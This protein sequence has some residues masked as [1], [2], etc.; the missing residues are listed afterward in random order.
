MNSIDGTM[1][2]YVNDKP[3]T[4]AKAGDKVHVIVTTNDGKAVKKL[5]VKHADGKADLLLTGDTFIMPE[6]DIRVVADIE[7]GYAITLETNYTGKAVATVGGLGVTA[8]SRDSKVMIV[9][10]DPTY[11][12]ESVSA[13]YRT[14]L[15]A[16]KDLAITNNGFAMPEAAVTVKVTLKPVSTFDF[17]VYSVSDISDLTTVGMGSFFLSVNNGQVNKAA[18][19]TE[20]KIVAQPL[21]GYAITGI[22]VTKHDDPSKMVSVFNNTFTMPAFDVDVIVEFG[23]KGNNIVIMPAKGGTAYA[24]TTAD[25]PATE[26]NTGVEVTLVAKPL[27]GYEIEHW[28]VVRNKDGYKVTVSSDKFMMPAGGVTVTPVFIGKENVAVTVDLYL[29]DTKVTSKDLLLSADV[30]VSGPSAATTYKVTADVSGTDVKGAA[31]PYVGDYISVGYSCP[32]NIAFEK[33]KINAGTQSAEYMNQLKTHD[34]FELADDTAV[35]IEVYFSKGKIAL[36]KAAVKGV[37]SVSYVSGVDLQSIGSAKANDK[38]IV[39]LN[40]GDHYMFDYSSDAFDGTFSKYLHVTRKDNGA[41]IPLTEWDKNSDGEIDGYIFTMPDCGI[42]V[43]AE[44]LSETYTIVMICKDV[45]DPNNPIDV[46]H[47]GLYQIKVGEEEAIADNLIS[48]HK[49]QLND[50][51]IA[52]M[53]DAGKSKYDMVS[54][55]I[56]GYDYTA[57]VNNYAYNFK[58]AD[59]RAMST[60][61]L[62]EAKLKAR[63]VAKQS[64]GVNFDASKGN[65]EF[66]LYK[67]NSPYSAAEEY[68]TS[69]AYIKSAYPGDL[70]GVLVA[71]TATSYNPKVEVKGGDATVINPSEI[72]GTVHGIDI[73]GD[74]AADNLDILYVFMMPNTYT[75]VNVAFEA[76]PY[77]VTFDLASSTMPDGSGGTKAVD[78]N[79]LKAAINGATYRDINSDT[80]TFPD[81]KTGNTVSVVRT[82]YCKTKGLKI[83]EMFVEDAGGNPISVKAVPDGFSFV[84]PSDDVTVTFKLVEDAALKTI[85]LNQ[86]AAALTIGKYK[87]DSGNLI[88]TAH[89]GD[90][91]RIYLADLILDKGYINAGA[92][93]EELLKVYEYGYKTNIATYDTTNKYWEFTMPEGGYALESNVKVLTYTLTFKITGGSGKVNVSASGGAIHQVVDGEKLVV[94]YNEAIAIGLVPGSGDKGFSLSAA[95]GTI[96]GNSYRATA[97]ADEDLNITLS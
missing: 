12:V 8:A 59:L 5:T 50:I 9:S 35:T 28:T 80:F 58:I 20:V 30:S 44:F 45:T 31:S 75:V 56:N 10:T 92:S 33:I 66:I 19:G 27:D 14:M 21:E 38:V 55:S 17:Y 36:P 47:T 3:V 86:P 39:K 71:P 95:A 81:A 15:G 83:A 91:V 34:F 49:A 96:S 43:Q 16:K 41:E 29:D 77:S 65:V 52:S 61:I 11:E 51:V 7:S 84:M 94:T 54:F 57:G 46:S 85:K 60:S 13:Y 87:D 88:T 1:S 62:I 89:P 90:K 97:L 48:Y 37:G 63:G 64:I 23:E 22:K 70:V 32:A 25:D 40:P 24:K 74:G 2:F 73:N 69:G 82:E 18:K 53:T 4:S 26:A 67:S 68:S 76:V 6:T 93:D 72:D 79:L 78:Y 42:D